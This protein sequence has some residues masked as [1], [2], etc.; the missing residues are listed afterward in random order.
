[1]YF[2]IFQSKLLAELEKPLP[3][4][5]AHFKLAPYKRLIGKNAREKDPS[6]KLSAVLALLFPKNNEPHILLTL[7]NTYKGVHSKQ[8][9]FP[10]G[11]REKI[12]TSF[13][14]TAL[15]E[16]EEEIG[17]NTKSIQILGKLTEVYIPPSR[18]L[19]HPFVGVTPSSPIFK[20]DAHEV[21][22]IIECPISQLLDD[23]IIKEKN[24]FLTT[25]QQKMKTKYFDVNGHVVWGATAIMLSELKDIIKQIV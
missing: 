3:G 1:M 15:R 18:F 5:E 22:E 25:T 16:T 4:I 7:R 6:P 19:V 9:S 24:I 17:I 2:D 11:K 14:Q 13:E 20:P 8:V 23:S 10:G 12:D 21:S